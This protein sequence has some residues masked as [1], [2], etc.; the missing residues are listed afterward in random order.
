MIT[1]L[2]C[3]GL[4]AGTL[5]TFSFLPQVIKILQ[6]RDVSSISLL[7]YSLFCFGVFLWLLYGIILESISLILTNSITLIFSLCVL[8]L[9]IY[10]E[11]K[12]QL[13]HASSL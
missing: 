5:T 4:C 6:T 9:K 13:K 10:I 1:L 12:N 7:M 3:L 11:R 8:T 2:E